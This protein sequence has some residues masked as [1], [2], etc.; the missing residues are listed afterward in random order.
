MAV[1]VFL[2]KDLALVVVGQALAPL[3]WGQELVEVSALALA[4]HQRRLQE[5][6]VGRP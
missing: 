1:F 4:T 3:V 6:F 5:V 2:V